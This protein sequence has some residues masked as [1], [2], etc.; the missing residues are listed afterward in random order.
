MTYEPRNQAVQQ[1]W[2]DKTPN[3]KTLMVEIQAQLKSLRSS[4]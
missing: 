1:W 2:A 3:G 4:S